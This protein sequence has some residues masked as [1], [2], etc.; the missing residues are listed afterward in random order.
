MKNLSV[1]II[2]KWSTLDCIT[3]SIKIWKVIVYTYQIEHCNLN[4][5]FHFHK[6]YNIFIETKLY[7]KLQLSF[8]V[9][10]FFGLVSRIALDYFKVLNYYL[11]LSLFDLNFIKILIKEWLGSVEWSE[12]I[13]NSVFIY[14]KTDVSFQ[15]QRVNKT[16]NTNICFV[17]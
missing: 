10:N 13:N 11:T 6:I 8:L 4:H 15:L 2:I 1:T 12:R 17:Y 14:D 5:R 16:K 3:L 9:S 7:L